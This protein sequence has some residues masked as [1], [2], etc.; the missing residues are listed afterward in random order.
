MKTINGKNCTTRFLSE[1]A[2]NN[3]GG[4]REILLSGAIKLAKIATAFMEMAFLQWVLPLTAPARASHP[5][6]LMMPT[7]IPDHGKL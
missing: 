7:D 4:G 2:A 5:P 6:E 3:I 1:K